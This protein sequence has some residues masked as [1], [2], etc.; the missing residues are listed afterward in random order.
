MAWSGPAVAVLLANLITSFAAQ[1]PAPFP[2]DLVRDSVANEINASFGSTHFAYE[3]RERTTDGSRARILVETRDATA[4]MLIAIDDMPLNARQRR[5]E[6]SRL[7]KLASNP[8]ALKKRHRQE[9]EDDERVNRILRAMPNA[10]LYQYDGT[11][12]AKPGMGRRGDELIRLR[13]SPNPA[14]DPPTHI[15]QVLTGMRG[16]V[17]IDANCK[18]IAKIGGTLFKDVGFGWGIL[19]HLDRGG[20][21]LIEQED[22][23]DSTWEITR[24]TLDFTG[25]LLLFKNLVIKSDETCSNFLRV[26]SD[27]SFAQGIALLEKKT[28]PNR[29]QVS[30]GIKSG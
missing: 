3:S 26:P 5:A 13:F 1:R 17:L 24:M 14:Y 19:G 28:L 4:S 12:S 18:R 25:K 27:L 7:A 22:V 2:A 21:F 20:H 10:L 11:E 30:T 9:K 15:E 23:G 6:E 8:E 16:Y 29:G